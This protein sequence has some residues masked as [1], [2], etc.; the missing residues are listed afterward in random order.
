MLTINNVISLEDLANH[1]SFDPVR[2]DKLVR[3]IITRANPFPPTKGIN[4][5]N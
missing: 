1:C 4:N 2:S 5:T 3:R